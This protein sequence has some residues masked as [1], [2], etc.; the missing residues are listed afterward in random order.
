LR[1]VDIHINGGGTPYLLRTALQGCCHEVLKVAGV[2]VPPT[3]R[4]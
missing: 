2:A 4:R 1:E 3:L